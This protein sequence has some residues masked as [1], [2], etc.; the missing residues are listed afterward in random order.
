MKNGRTDPC[1]LFSYPNTSLPHVRHFSLNCS[2]CLLAAMGTTYLRTRITLHLTYLRQARSAGGADAC[3]QQPGRCRKVSSRDVRWGQSIRTRRQ[4][5]FV[6]SL[7]PSA[8]RPDKGI[9]N[10]HVNLSLLNVQYRGHLAGMAKPKA[11]WSHGRGRMPC[12]PSWQMWERQR[13]MLQAFLW[14]HTD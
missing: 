8:L 14:A 4:L 5:C 7:F 3:R 13:G 2:M 11:P 1:L 10:S 6:T 9:V 12:G